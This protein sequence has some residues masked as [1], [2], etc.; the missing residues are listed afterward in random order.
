MIQKPLISNVEEENNRNSPQFAET[1]MKKYKK[2]MDW[3]RNIVRELFS[4][5]ILN[6]KYQICFT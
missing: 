5:D 1:T 6:L 2:H 3:R 4:S